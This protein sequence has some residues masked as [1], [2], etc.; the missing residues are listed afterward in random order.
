[1]KKGKLIIDG[2]EFSW[3]NGMLLAGGEDGRSKIKMLYT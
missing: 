2:V 3:K 1:M